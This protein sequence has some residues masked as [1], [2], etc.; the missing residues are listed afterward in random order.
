MNRERIR[1]FV[2]DLIYQLR[3]F[4]T[5]ERVFGASF[6]EVVDIAREIK[7]VC[8]Q[9]RV[10]REDKR[11]RGSGSF[12]GV[13]S[14]GQFQHGRGHPFRHAQP[15]RL[16]HCGGSSCHGLTVHIS[17]ETPSIDSV[18]IVRDFPDVFPADLSGMPQDKDIEFGIDL[19]PGT[20]P[21]SIPS[22][23]MTSTELK[24]QLQELLDKVFIRPNVS[25]WGA[26]VLF[27]K[28][29]DVIMRMCIDYR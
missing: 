28:K 7:S 5:R 10:E 23:R 27:V 18:P 29:N 24:E 2:D 6:E 16:S 20:Q 8:H 25:P 22:Y 14:G 15:A 13:P 12:D 4:L 26:H 21:I 19:V 17:T 3:I 1:R 9:E 11:P